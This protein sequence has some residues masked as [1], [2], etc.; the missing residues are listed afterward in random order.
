MFGWF[1]KSRLKLSYDVHSHLLPGLDDG[2]KS[3]E[4]SIAILRFFEM[5]GV[6]KVITT[7]H[8]Y[9]N[10]Y[11]NSEKSILNRLEVLKS[12]IADEGL[13]VQIEAAA[14]YFLDDEFIS[15]VKKG[16]PL[17]T[18][19]GS[20]LLIE[21]SF[22][23]RPLYFDEA[24]FELRSA[25]YNPV[26]AHPERYHYLEGNLEWLTDRI[27][28][29]LDVQV[30]LLSLAGVYGKTPHKIAKYLLKESLVSFLGSDIHREE[31]LKHLS[32][33]LT[34]NISTGKVRNITQ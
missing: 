25:G 23:N 3:F 29:G 34:K 27:S 32:E 14:E 5:N 9:K 21:T 13:S 16:E 22:Y 2:V 33:V 31:Q 24:L 11:P 6:N 4:E 15:R 30:N 28:E 20:N 10:V 19:E 18:W 8:I 12:K 26:L 7:P 1:A 17:L